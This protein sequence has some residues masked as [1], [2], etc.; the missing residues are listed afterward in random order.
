MSGHDTRRRIY[1][2]M[3]FGDRYL[4]LLGINRTEKQCL[5]KTSVFKSA[6]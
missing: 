5:Y 1:P 4:L 3:I 2:Y 6:K